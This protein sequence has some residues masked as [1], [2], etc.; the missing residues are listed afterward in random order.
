M[1]HEAP[2]YSVHYAP[3]YYVNPHQ[4]QHFVSKKGAAGHHVE[5]K[6]NS[7]VTEG[8]VHEV[9]VPH[10]ETVVHREVVHEPVVHH[11][12]VSEPVVHREVVHEPVVHEVVHHVV[13]HVQPVVHL[14][15]SLHD[16]HHIEH[17]DKVHHMEHFTDVHHDLPI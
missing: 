15:D 9:V 11:E 4:T 5:P 16:D 8:L 6:A 3:G 12:V 2:D 7:E 10:H 13:E 14:D 17:M 1:T